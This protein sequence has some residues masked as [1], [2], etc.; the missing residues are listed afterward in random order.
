MKAWKVLPVFSLALLWSVTAFA[1]DPTK[2]A[3]A[4]YKVILENPSVRMSEDHLRAGSQER[5]CTATRTP[6]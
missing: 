4:N 1:Q 6:S 2:V 5:H 3:A